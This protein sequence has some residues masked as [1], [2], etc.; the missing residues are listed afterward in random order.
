[1][2]GIVIAVHRE[3]YEVKTEEQ[4]LYAR[5]KS[6]VYYNQGTEKFPT[7]G[8]RVELQFYPNGDSMITKTLERKSYFSRQDPDVGMGEQVV[9]ANF[10]YVFLVMSLNQ[11]FNLDRLERYL[12]QAWQSG[13]TPV[14]ILTKADLCEDLQEKMMQVEK[15]APGVDIHAVSSVTGKGM[16]EVQAYLKVGKSVVLLGSSGVGKSTLVNVLAGEEVM[17]TGEIRL[18][19]DKGKHTTTHRQMIELPQGAIIID[20]PGMRELGIWEAQDG[21]SQA[22]SEIEELISR[23]RFSNC[24]HG[25][26]PGCAVH[27]ALEDGSLDKKRWIRYQKLEKENRMRAARNQLAE[28]RQQKKNKCLHYKNKYDSIESSNV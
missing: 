14:V 13:G 24:S 1:M 7:V 10:D 12:A 21:M 28:K 3:R 27:A 22:F 5:L 6:G 2:N 23:C 19:D 4:K 26:E 9:A 15:I 17:E 20:T 11:N 8:D 16:E 18:A 25:N